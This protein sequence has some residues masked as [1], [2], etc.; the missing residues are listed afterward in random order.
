M[1]DW[2]IGFR[3]RS[4]PGPGASPVVS[5]AQSSPASDAVGTA[6]FPAGRS[7]K[8]RGPDQCAPVM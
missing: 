3:W 5:D 2:G 1:G 8:K 4:A 7:P 6:R